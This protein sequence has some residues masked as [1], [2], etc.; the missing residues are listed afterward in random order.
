MNTAD[1][2]AREE[3]S[4]ESSFVRSFMLTGGRTTPGHV[5]RV[6]TVL[7]H[8]GG[9]AGP[10]AVVECHRIVALCQERRRSVAELAGTLHRPVA[11][12]KVLVSD[13]LDVGALTVPLPVTGALDDDDRPTRQLLEAAMAGLRRKWPNA[14]PHP[15]PQAG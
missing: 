12:V 11:T 4:E 14:N 8:G 2:G 10:G 6:D 15:Y 7:A 5:L 3:P 9:R 1:D 13:L